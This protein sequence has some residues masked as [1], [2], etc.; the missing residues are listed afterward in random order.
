MNNPTPENSQGLM[1]QSANGS[2]HYCACC[3]KISVSYKNIMLPLSLNGLDSWYTLLENKY[4]SLSLETQSNCAVRVRVSGI[5]VS[6]HPEELDE[7]LELIRMARLEIQRFKLEKLFQLNL[8]LSP[9]HETQS[10]E[11]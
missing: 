2:I 11:H 1:A 10:Y 6:F 8:S 3:A 7:I 9:A 4:L 5:F